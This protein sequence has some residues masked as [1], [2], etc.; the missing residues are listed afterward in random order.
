MGNWITRIPLCVDGMEIV[1]PNCEGVAIFALYEYIGEACNHDIPDAFGSGVQCL[2][3]WKFH[4]VKN[5][6][7]WVQWRYEQLVTDPVLDWDGTIFVLYH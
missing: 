5:L 7:E 6:S 2:C 4:G 1:G 3:S